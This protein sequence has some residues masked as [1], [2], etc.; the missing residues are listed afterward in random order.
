MHSLNSLSIKSLAWIDSVWIY[1][2]SFLII[3]TEN[4]VSSTSA[5]RNTFPANGG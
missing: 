1:S 2:V 5:T 4:T 3:A